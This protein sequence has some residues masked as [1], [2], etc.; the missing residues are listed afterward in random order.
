[1]A[2]SCG[3]IK[4]MS[5]RDKRNN[6]R[7]PLTPKRRRENQVSPPTEWLGFTVADQGV[8]KAHETATGNSIVMR[9]GEQQP[10]GQFKTM[11]EAFSY[12]KEM[13]GVVRWRSGVWS[14]GS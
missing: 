9:T 11:D 4:G 3:N 1:M 7:G 10:H 8:C 2:F 6:E 5:K 13:F 14:S 12:G